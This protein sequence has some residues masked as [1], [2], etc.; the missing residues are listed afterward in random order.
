MCVC[1][2]VCV[3]AEVN[4]GNKYDSMKNI[5]KQRIPNAMNLL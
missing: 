3:C 5:E 2:C 4:Y 1:V